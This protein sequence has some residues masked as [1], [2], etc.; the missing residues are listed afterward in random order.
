M[1]KLIIPV[2]MVTILAFAGYS[3]SAQETPGQTLIQRI[4]QRFN[5]DEAE[6]QKVFEEEHRALL[7]ERLN[8]AVADGKISE[9]RKQEI[10]SRSEEVG[11]HHFGGKFK[12][13]MP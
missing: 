7:E 6:V 10:L 12:M 3:V 11:P 9:K 8:K 4:A 1:K 13:R 2:V 5:L